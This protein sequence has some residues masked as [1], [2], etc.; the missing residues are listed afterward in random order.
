M[1][2]ITGLC[3]W[4]RRLGSHRRCLTVRFGFGA[5]PPPWSD[6]PKSSA[7]LLQHTASRALQTAGSPDPN[8][9]HGVV[10]CSC[11]GACNKK[12]NFEDV[13]DFRD[14]VRGAAVKY[15]TEKKVPALYTGKARRADRNHNGTTSGKGPVQVA[16]EKFPP[17]RGLCFG[18]YGESSIYVEQMILR[19][20]QRQAEQ[21]WQSMGA[22]SVHEA[23]AVLVGRLRRRV[24][25]M[26][27]RT[28]AEM[29]ST[30][31]AQIRDKWDQGKRLNKL[32]FRLLQAR[33]LSHGLQH[34]VQP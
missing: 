6:M 3:T 22:R 14:G 33:L 24:G 18:P 16:L 1:A 5:T 28:H 34:A 31:L 10:A 7:R 12:S 2:I 26:A 25:V 21:R 17:M 15:Y 19:C 27:V 20:A 9:H 30:R 4:L 13:R 23:S 29:K 32:H 8:M 11:R